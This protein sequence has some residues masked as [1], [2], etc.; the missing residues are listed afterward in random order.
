MAGMPL[1]RA[2][3]AVAVL[4]TRSPHSGVETKTTAVPFSDDVVLVAAVVAADGY[5]ISENATT[6]DLQ[7]VNGERNYGW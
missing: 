5:P 1:P 4:S 6:A 7:I 3:A 2:S